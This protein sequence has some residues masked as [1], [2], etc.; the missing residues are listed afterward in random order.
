MQTNRKTVG[1]ATRMKQ[2]ID[3]GA[4]R[5][6]KSALVSFSLVR[7]FV[8]E[9]YRN[10]SEG[11]VSLVRA[12]RAAKRLEGSPFDRHRLQEMEKHVEALKACWRVSRE[13]Q[14][15]LGCIIIDMAPRID[16]MTTMEQRLELLNCNPVDTGELPE[17]DIGLVELIGVYCV[18]DSAAHRH[19]EFNDRPLHAAVNAEIIRVMRETREGRAA[20]EK[21]FD[22][23][24]APGGIFHGVS[25][26]YR[27]PDGTMKR[28]APALVVHDASG[29]RVIERT[30]S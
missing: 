18:E 10:I 23:A 14:Q 28:K 9:N 8:R 26:Y 2:A 17:P 20:S 21:I 27:Q 13:C 12:K 6:E 29:S 16:A 4:F 3:N 11:R 22:E 25:T 19:D 30:P 1:M 24:F 5:N 7:H 15:A